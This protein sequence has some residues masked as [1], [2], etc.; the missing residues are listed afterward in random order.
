MHLGGHVL[1]RENGLVLTRT[2]EVK[3][4]MEEREAEKDQKE[5]DG[6]EMCDGWYEG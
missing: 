5:T 2:F 4:Q 6:G 3:G 1:R